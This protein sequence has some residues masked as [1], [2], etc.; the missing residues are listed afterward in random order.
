M[1][2]FHSCV[3]I[4]QNISK[5]KNSMSCMCHFYKIYDLRNCDVV[6]FFILTT[7]LRLL[8]IAAVFEQNNY[9]LVFIPNMVVIKSHCDLLIFF[10]PIMN[11]MQLITN[12][13]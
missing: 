12:T 3:K 4:R 2:N 8:V 6:S 10:K 13:Q 1:M 9:A 7:A 5:G 11:A